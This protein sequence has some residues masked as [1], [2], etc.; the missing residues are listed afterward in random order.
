MS[1]F[2]EPTTNFNDLFGIRQDGDT[3][4]LILLTLSVEVQKRTRMKDRP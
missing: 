2:L 4:S 1:N 3:L